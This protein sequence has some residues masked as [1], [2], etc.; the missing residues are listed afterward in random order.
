MKPVSPIFTP[1]QTEKG[2]NV[3]ENLSNK[4]KVDFL[5]EVFYIDEHYEITNL[6][7]KGTYGMV[8]KGI[9]KITGKEVAIK[10][11][12][13]LFKDLQ[14]AKRILREVRILSIINII[15]S[16]SK[17]KMSSSSLTLCLYRMMNSSTKCT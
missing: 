9:N 7:G 10:K 5:G 11:M 2:K 13:N 12:S 15:K 8:A 17:A 16:F 3:E 14:D 6:I 1:P 4:K